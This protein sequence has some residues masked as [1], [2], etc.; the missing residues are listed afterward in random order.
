MVA[1]C[2]SLYTQASDRPSRWYC[3]NVQP[4]TH[5]TMPKEQHTSKPVHLM[6]HS[7]MI[8]KISTVAVNG[9]SQCTKLYQFLDKKAGSSSPIYIWTIAMAEIK[10]RKSGLML[11]GHWNQQVYL[12]SSMPRS[13]G[14]SATHRIPCA[15]SVPFKLY[16][17]QAAIML[18]WA[19]APGSGLALAAWGDLFDRIIKDRLL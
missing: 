10:G 5:E 13:G 4:L 11:H 17:I 3:Q 16:N 9:C 18:A 15:P 1:A 12:I 8:F 2:E 7:H 14:C 19:E 6:R